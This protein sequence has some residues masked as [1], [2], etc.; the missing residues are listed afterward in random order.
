M[1]PGASGHRR[2]GSSVIDTLQTLTCTSGG[3]DGGSGHYCHHH[4]E[5]SLAKFLEQLRKEQKEK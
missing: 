5:E 1:F 2:T 4:H 3:N